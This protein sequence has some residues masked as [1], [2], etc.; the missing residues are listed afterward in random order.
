[1]VRRVNA[2]TDRALDYLE[3][4][5]IKEGVNAGAWRADNNAINA[6]A[7]LA[8]LSRGHVPG[9]GKYGDT[10][11]DGVVK[12]GVLTLAKKFI[13]SR[14]SKQKHNE[15]YLAISGRMY[16]H[17]LTTLALSEMYG[18]D[19]DPELEGGVRKAVNLILRSQGPV[20][21]WNYEPTASDG[22]L[23]VS[24][25]QIVA[26]RAASNAEIPVP[27][28]TIKKAIAYVRQ[29]AA[30]GGPGYGY[31]G[32]GDGP[33]TSAAGCLSLQL[34][35]AYNDPQIPKTLDYLVATIRPEVW[36]GCGASYYYYFHYYA[37]QAFYQHGGKHWNEW[38]PAVREMLL[39]NQNKDGSWDA[40][41]GAEIGIDPQTKTYTTALATLVLNIYQHF[42][43]AY[44]R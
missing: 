38:H 12:P 30:P 20:G 21:G 8:F 10:V 27:E 24:V 36:K 40:P 9:R 13:L 25:M 35:G 44:Q 28:T 23:S 7:I 3:K 33:Q 31:A 32:P 22:D 6:L 11:E 5:Q 26:M 14:Q 41:D 4:K 39:A 1:M 42:L 19:P 2:A 18:M 29:M 15:G 16:G 17:G 34:L 37:M 43:P